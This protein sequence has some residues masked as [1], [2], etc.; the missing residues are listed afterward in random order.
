[1]AAV[2]PDRVVTLGSFSNVNDYDVVED[3]VYASINPK[4]GREA[5]ATKALVGSHGPHLTCYRKQ[6]VPAR[7]HY[8]RNPRVPGILCMPDVGWLVTAKPP[9]KVDGGAHG[10]DNFAPDMLALF[11]ATGP[12][13]RPLG[14]LPSFDNVDVAPLL[15]DLI[16]L[17]PGTGLDGDDTPFLGALRK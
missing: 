13:I 2:S 14:T 10:Y 5:A 1:M 11:I 12:A 8:G 4:P 9:K 16:G 7:L 3:G 15:R 17:P 6:D